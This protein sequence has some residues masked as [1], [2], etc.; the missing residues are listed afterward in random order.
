MAPPFRTAPPSA[1]IPA[2]DLVLRAADHRAGAVRGAAIQKSI[3]PATFVRPQPGLPGQNIQVKFAAQNTG[4]LWLK[5]LIVQ[6]HRTRRSSTPS[7]CAPP[8]R[9]GS[10]S[11]PAPTGS[12]S[13]PAPERADRRTSSPARPTASQS[14]PLPIAAADVRG[15]RVT[16]L[17]ADGSF[18]IKPGTNFPATGLCTGA[19]ICLNV[20]PRAELRSAPGTPVPD[21][22]DRHRDRRLRDRLRRAAI[23]PD[24]RHIGHPFPDHGTAALL[25]DKGDD[26]D[27]APGTRSRSPSPPRTPAPG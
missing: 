21:R 19:S 6:R 27:V 7:T 22:I 15:I 10:T 1:R 24:S 26:I 3:V 20:S 23:G 9:S 2:A 8:I 5:Q 13:T 16:F 17:T 11:R 12:G 4:T 18:T 14:P 25:F